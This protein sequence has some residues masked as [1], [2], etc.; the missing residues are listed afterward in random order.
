MRTR[1]G[2]IG[3]GNMGAAII[4][5]IRGKFSVGVAE[6]D[7]KRRSFLRSSFNIS[8][9]DVPTLAARCDVLV[10]AVKPQDLEATLQEI[11][12]HI[13]KRHLVISIAAGI[14]T[15]YIEKRLGKGVRVIR[16]MPNLPAQIG[17]GVTAIAQGRYAR[18]NDLRMAGKIFACVGETIDVSEQKIDAITAVSGSGPAYVFMFVESVLRAARSVGLSPQESKALVEKTCWGSINLLK[19][20]GEA[21]EL[22]RKKVTSKGGTTEA[23]M[24]LFEE[25][26]FQEMFTQAVKAAKKRAKELSK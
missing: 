2:I 23:A 3:A 9:V 19:K 5:G 8:A 20:S 11:R 17:E 10:L 1:I 22:L 4:K 16:T 18:K 25:K 15:R 21:A 14:T 13:L 12:A 26:K 7:G 6:K 24:K